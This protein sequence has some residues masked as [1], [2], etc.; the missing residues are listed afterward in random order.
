MCDAVEEI[1]VDPPLQ[2][3]TRIVYSS[4]I[5]NNL[6][7]VLKVLPSEFLQNLPSDGHTMGTIQHFEGS[8]QIIRLCYKSISTRESSTISHT[9][10]AFISMSIGRVYI[11][12]AI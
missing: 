1:R 4:M 9:C 2:E 8:F 11:V 10:I 3:F 7:V 5:V 12:S 6:T